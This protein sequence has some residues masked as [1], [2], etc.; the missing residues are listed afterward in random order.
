[1]NR[2]RTS[3]FPKFGEMGTRMQAMEWAQTPVG[4]VES[5][6]QSLKSTVRTLLGSRYPMILLWE[7]ELIQIYN[8]AYINLIGTKHPY[9]LGRSIRETQAE[10]W[11]VI[12]PMI[13]EVMTTGVPNWVEDQML[14]VNRSGYNEEAHFSLSYSAVE[15]DAGKIRGMLCVCSEV[16]QQVLGERRLRLQRDLAARAGETRSVDTTCQDILAT[17]AECPLDVPFALIYLRDSNDQTLKLC[18]SVGMNGNAAIVPTTVLLSEALADTADR[19]SLAKAMAGQTAIVSELDRDITI[20][21][22]PWNESVS[23]AIALP[24]PSSN[25]AAPLGVLICGISPNRGL[26]EGYQSFYEL[27]AGQVSVS[28]R[29]AQAYEEERRRA[30]MLAELD[31]AKTVFFSN[32]S[33]EFRTPLTLMLNPLEDLLQSDQLPA[34]EREQIAVAHRNSQRLLKLVNTLLDF[35]RIEAG[36]IQAVYEATDLASLTADLASVFRSAIEKAGMQLVVNC[37]PLPEPVYVDREMWEK[38]VLNLLSN[39][40]KFTFE[41]QISVSLRPVDAAVELVVQDTGTGIP[42]HELPRLFER[43]HRVAGA[44]GRSYEGSG[45]GLS[46]VQELVKLHGG[47]VT[48]SSVEKEGSTFVVR[49]PIGCAHLPSEQIQSVRIQASTATG[50]AAYVEEALEWVVERSEDSAG[51]PARVSA[52]ILLADDNADMR[53]YL[54]RLLKEHYEVEAVA[55]GQA[56]LESARAQ[57]PDL[58]LT[59]V[60]M[61]RLDGFEL[62]RQLR[63][64]SQ[65]REIPILLLSARAGEEAAVEGL[66]AGADD[67]LVKPFSARE[68]LARVATNLELGRSRRV[69]SQQRFRFLAESIPQ[70]VWTADAQGWVDYY[71]PRWFDYTGLTLA[72]TQGLGWQEIIHPDDRADSISRWSQAA[73]QK[74]SYDVEHRLRRADGSYCWHLTRALPMLDEQSQ[75]IRWF[76]TCTDITERK[77]AEKAL[78]ESTEQLSLA[79]AAAKLGDW[80]W[81]VATDIV[82][83]TEQAAE[84]F[85][86]PPGPYMTWTQMQKLLHPDDRERA[87]SQV[88]E[89]IAEH[90]DYDVEY[91]V[92]HPDETE[93]CIAAKGRAQYD[94]FGQ[95]LG[96][97][98]VV[99]DITQRK[100]AEQ[101]REKLLEREQNA[102]REA[103]QANRIKDEFL[104]VLS[105]ELRSPL[106]PILGWSKLLQAHQFDEAATRRALQ[107]IERNAKLQTQLIDDLLDVSRILRGKM[108]LDACPVNLVT[109]VDAA[110]ETVHLAAEAKG[111]EVQKVI[112]S[113][114][115]LVS[116]DVARLQ[117]VVWN[118]L[119]NAIKFTPSGG[120]VEIRLAQTN[121]H[122]QIQ[123]Q[124]TGKGIAPQFLPHVFEYFRQEDGATTRKFGGLGLG[125]AIVQHLTELHGG[126]VQAESPGEGLGATFTVLLPASKNRRGENSGQPEPLSSSVKAF[127]LAGLQVLAVDDQADMQELVSAILEQA[128]AEIK[129]TTSAIEA[130]EAL[131]VFKPDVVI[132]DI[133]MPEMDGYELLRQIRRRSPEDNGDVLAIALTAY[134]GELNQQQ[135]FAAGFQG[136]VAKPVEPEKLVDVIISLIKEK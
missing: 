132:S 41:G 109:V 134:A 100:Q 30:E 106:N 76:G 90:S 124:D 82:T 104:A 71:S 108:M 38:I 93:R 135:A 68:L 72:Q 133:G 84:I 87:G 75:V 121:T 33:H 131:D 117:Q 6:S 58:V 88:E 129:V 35:S 110:L 107:T 60:M 50:A 19:W 111:I 22:G 62:L 16:T 48:A 80:S 61:P 74:T 53:H 23:Q 67:Y 44:R 34:A 79:L 113:K 114:I 77:Q 59:D 85:G 4:A 103:E 57:L 116:G 96:M 11:D 24:I 29:N 49:L 42:A 46:L 65:T 94:S 7:Q 78:K 17:I 130:L 40:F 123:V 39:A 101:E 105:H 56:A 47:T 43:F 99:Q 5:W 54:Q 15:D 28:I 52:R 27:L 45:I 9:A 26:D 32:V 128:G 81:N 37:L 2:H 69:A 83:F 36:R 3:P 13:T 98:G 127:P 97:L 18:G 64:D 63:A 125:L 25:V 20:A 86:I 91:R 118:L 136:H 10:S 14:A 126:T 31:R 92:I 12:G 119:S 55:D 120:T 89:A 51:V 21:G 122:V 1:M 8:D 66:E 95:V 115:E 102:R 70:M 112:A 73:E